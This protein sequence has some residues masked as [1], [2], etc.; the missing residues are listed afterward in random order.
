M[1]DLFPELRPGESTSNLFVEEWRKNVWKDDDRNEHER[2]LPLQQL[3]QKSQNLSEQHELVAK[4]WPFLINNLR[5][6]SKEIQE[7]AN[8]VYKAAT[9]KSLDFGDENKAVE[10][11]FT[12]LGQAEMKHIIDPII[13]H[14]GTQKGKEY[15]TLQSTLEEFRGMYIY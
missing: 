14:L 5:P 7:S 9:R 11:C 15:K 2:L 3:A 4:I 10:R 12:L 1:H 6:L 8:Q 13:S